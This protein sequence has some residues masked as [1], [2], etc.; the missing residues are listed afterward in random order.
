MLMNPAQLTESGRRL[1]GL[2]SLEGDRGAPAARL[3]ERFDSPAPCFP[4]P[5]VS[6]MKSSWLGGVQEDALPAL[7]HG[8]CHLSI[9]APCRHLP[10][11]CSQLEVGTR[12]CSRLGTRVS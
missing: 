8:S 7:H 3:G 11:S 10:I 4:S 5:A 1:R 9:C 2:R 12:P 6:G